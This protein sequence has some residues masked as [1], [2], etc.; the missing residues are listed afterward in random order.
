MTEAGHGSMGARGGGAAAR[1]ST[2]REEAA[3]EH[4]GYSHA[5]SKDKFCLRESENLL[6]VVYLFFHMLHSCDKRK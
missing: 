2:L 4:E 3:P 5:G 1:C 6:P